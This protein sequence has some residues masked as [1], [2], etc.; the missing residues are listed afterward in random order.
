MS[1][2][3]RI[4]AGSQMNEQEKNQIMLEFA[5]LNTSINESMSQVNQSL[6]QQ[7]TTNRKRN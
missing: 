7:Q 4:E 6:S 5:K 1:E 3:K 2:E